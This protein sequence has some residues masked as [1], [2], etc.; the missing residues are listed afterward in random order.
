MSHPD[1]L[2]DPEN[3]YTEDIEENL[4][5]IE[6]LCEGINNNLKD[7]RDLNIKV[8]QKLQG[9]KDVAGL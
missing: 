2:Y 5:K 4:R 8:Q 1:P 7:I 6:E 9:F 3:S